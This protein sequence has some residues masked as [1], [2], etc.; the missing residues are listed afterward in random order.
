MLQ[1]QLWVCATHMHLNLPSSASLRTWA[2]RGVAG[3]QSVIMVVHNYRR[4]IHY[5]YTYMAQL[6]HVWWCRRMPEAHHR[7]QPFGQGNHTGRRR[8]GEHTNNNRQAQ[9][10]GGAAWGIVA[11]G[12]ALAALVVRGAASLAHSRVTHQVLIQARNGVAAGLTF[13]TT[14]CMRLKRP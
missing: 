9:A 1:S 3:R 12:V 5:M 13:A 4:S 11:A 2:S 7:S 8:A 6:N 14:A 10:R